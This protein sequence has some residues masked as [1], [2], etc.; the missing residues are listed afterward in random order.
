MLLNA[1][2]GS[3]LRMTYRG[4]AG[5]LGGMIPTAYRRNARSLRDRQAFEVE[6]SLLTR[7]PPALRA[8]AN[9][10]VG[11]P[12][13]TSPRTPALHAASSSWLTST[14]PALPLTCHIRRGSGHARSIKDMSHDLRGS[15]TA[16]T[17][18]LTRRGTSTRAGSWRYGPRRPGDRS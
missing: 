7:L 6:S 17:G 15:R 4:F 14:S 16:T 10:A 18:W 13:R 9:E 1:K 8:L 3:P 12:G 5:S 11:H 2:E